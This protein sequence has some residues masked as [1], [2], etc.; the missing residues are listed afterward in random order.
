LPGLTVAGIDISAY[1]IEN[2]LETVKHV[3]KSATPRVAYADRS[4]DFVC[5]I[6][7]IHNLPLADC[8]TA[9]RHI[10][11]VSRGSASLWW[12]P[13]GRTKSAS[14]LEQWVLTCKTYMHVDEWKA[15]FDKVGYTGDYYWFIA[16]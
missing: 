14:A 3:C 7:T 4:F 11:R 9:L 6:N 1:A 15:L 2:A 16:A 5:A 13:T 10:Q 8:K 12:M